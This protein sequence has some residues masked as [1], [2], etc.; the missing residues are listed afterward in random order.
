MFYNIYIILYIIIDLYKYY[1]SINNIFVHLG[2]KILHD[3]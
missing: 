2:V 1:F 3:S